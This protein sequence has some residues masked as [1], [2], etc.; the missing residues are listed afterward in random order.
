MLY[1]YQMNRS[2]Y[3]DL[4][5]K[6]KI[7]CQNYSLAELL[8]NKYFSRCFVLY[9]SE[10]WKREYQGG[11]W[12]WDPIFSSITE[13]ELKI[14]QVGIRSRAIIEAL[15]YWKYNITL[16]SGKKYLGAIVAN[17][18]IPSKFIQAASRNSPVVRILQNTIRFATENT[19]NERELFTYVKITKN[20]S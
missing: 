8:K 3:N 12:S 2:E 18:G 16:V 6:L 9:A 10:W 1:A 14:H 13:E 15:Q 7:C 20:P 11:V 19:S 5:N 4:Q 17:G